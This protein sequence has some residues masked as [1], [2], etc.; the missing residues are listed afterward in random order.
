MPQRQGGGRTMLRERY[1]REMANL[2]DYVKQLEAARDFWKGNSD[3][4]EK[5]A[6]T[7]QKPHD[8]AEMGLD[9]SGARK[10]VTA[11]E[12]EA[13]L[14]HANALRQAYLEDRDRWQVRA[15]AWEAAYRAGLPHRIKSSVKQMLSGPL[16]ALRRG[17][18][19]S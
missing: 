13:A 17:R 5:A 3:A 7:F 1:Q 11:G 9:G 2:M 14:T 15:E 10:G 16:G 4:W 12:L 19:R 18:D 8:P 6:T